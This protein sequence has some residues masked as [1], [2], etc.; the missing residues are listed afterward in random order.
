MEDEAGFDEKIVAVPHG[1]LTRYYDKI[2]TYTDLPQVLQ[3]RIG[4]KNYKG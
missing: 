1:A 4:I 2:K 3:D